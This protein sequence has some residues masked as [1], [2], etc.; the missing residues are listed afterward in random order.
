[1]S[2]PLD[3]N[4]AVRDVFVAPPTRQTPVGTGRFSA[5]NGSPEH[6]VGS[7]PADATEVTNSQIPIELNSRARIRSRPTG[8]GW[9]PDLRC[10]QILEPSGMASLVRAT[11]RNRS[12]LHAGP[13]EKN[14]QTGPGPS[15]LTLTFS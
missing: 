3:R 2:A 10:H 7:C 15:L 1:M 9:R 5:S 11:G 4:A 14:E 6:A 13:D 8:R 12:G